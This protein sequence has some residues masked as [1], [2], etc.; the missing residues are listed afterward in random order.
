[1]R[2]AQ[3]LKKKMYALVDVDAKIPTW[4]LNI[5]WTLWFVYCSQSEFIEKSETL[6]QNLLQEKS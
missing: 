5:P 6:M 4:I 2:D 1:M 3:Q